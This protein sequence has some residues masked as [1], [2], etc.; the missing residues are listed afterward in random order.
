MQVTDEVFLYETN[1]GDGTSGC[2]E[3]AGNDSSETAEL[4]NGLW[5]DSHICIGLGYQDSLFQLHIYDILIQ[6]KLF[7][8]NIIDSVFI[9][10]GDNIVFND[11]YFFE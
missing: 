9:V 10:P 3:K 11:N 5:Q 6:K 1:V 2:T 7:Y 8:I 4:Y